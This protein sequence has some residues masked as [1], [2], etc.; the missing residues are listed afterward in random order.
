MENGNDIVL[1]CG[2]LAIWEAHDKSVPHASM[3]TIRWV[4]AAPILLLGAWAILYNW[5]LVVLFVRVR[6]FGC[7]HKWEPSAPLAGPLFIFLGLSVAPAPELL[8][9]SWV[10][11]VFEQRLPG[12]ANTRWI[13]AA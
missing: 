10:W 9:Y 11:L 4:L 8:R 7:H 2:A 5:R 3:N 6:F 12:I 13:C 1:C